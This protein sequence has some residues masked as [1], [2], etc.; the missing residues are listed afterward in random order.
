MSD[1]TERYRRKRVA[2]IN[3]DPG[4]RADL[5]AQHGQVWSTEELSQD[6][7][8]RKPAVV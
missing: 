6:W 7:L 8:C 2:E 3:A 4:N 5:E 1:A